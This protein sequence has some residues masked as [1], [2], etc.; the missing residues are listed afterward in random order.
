MLQRCCNRQEV[1]RRT[2]TCTERSVWVSVSVRV[3]ETRVHSARGPKPPRAAAALGGRHTR[4]SCNSNRT[5]IITITTSSCI[6][7]FRAAIVESNL[8]L[9][10]LK[11]WDD[12]IAAWS[13]KEDHEQHEP[14]SKTNA[15]GLHSQDIAGNVEGYAYPANGHD[16]RGK[17]VLV[18]VGA[19]MLIVGHQLLVMAV[20]DG[21]VILYKVDE[22]QRMRP[23]A[24]EKVNA[25]HRTG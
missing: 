5:M 6:Q 4:S 23:V 1:Q 13:A 20:S 22:L 10:V 7:S 14:K 24:E 11:S 17:G 18:V 21:H 15:V 12:I 25:L 3:L 16:L 2:S 9:I 19:G 8:L